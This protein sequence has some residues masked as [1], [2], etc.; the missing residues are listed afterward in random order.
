[1]KWTY[2]VRDGGEWYF[3]GDEIVFH[4]EG[5]EDFENFAVMAAENKEYANLI[6]AAPDLLEAL[7]GLVKQDYNVATG[8]IIDMKAYA[9]AI[10]AILIAK[11]ETNGG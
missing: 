2:T 10:D 8:R 1:M 6:A 11:G 3:S 5:T 4:P 9:K 7:E